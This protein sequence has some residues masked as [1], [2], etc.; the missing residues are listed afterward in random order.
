MRPAM[1]EGQG[2]RIAFFGT[3]GLL[4]SRA[5]EALSTE[6]RVVA[7]IHPA[8][9]S[10]G[11]LARARHVLR[12]LVGGR[13]P[14]WTA[15]SGD[16][17]AIAQRLAEL[18]PDLV[19]IAGY[20]WILPSHLYSAVPL[21]AINVH[22]S[23]LPRHRGILPLL[24]IYYHD[25]RS[26]GVTVHQVTA[27]ADAG[28]I[29]AQQSFPLERGFP[30]EE[31]NRFNAARGAALLRDSV[32]AVA[33]GQTAPRPQVEAEASPAPMVR[34]G[35]AMV[36]FERWPVER[37]WHFLAGLYPRFTE[38]LTTAD[39]E[40]ASYAGVLGFQGA[41]PDGAPGSV[42]ADGAEWRLQCLDGWVR[43]ARSR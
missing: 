43:L 25:D 1:V 3:N 40:A 10:G 6:H 2:L 17:P 41:S 42:S 33:T 30:V 12:D 24:W 32:R 21:G 34:P 18:R 15:R 11:L 19:C 5:L 35:S 38:P 8:R 16:D 29:L 23:L 13:P 28:D 7:V 39:G 36:D 27:R 20:P 14:S 31:L 4:S 9:R 22:G 26:T 37:V